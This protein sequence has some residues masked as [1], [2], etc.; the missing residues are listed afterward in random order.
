M[1]QIPKDIWAELTKEQKALAGKWAGNLAIIDQGGDIDALVFSDV[2]NMY[3]DHMLLTIN[4]LGGIL[5]EVVR[6]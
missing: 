4:P 1:K 2:K 3:S 5:S 6:G